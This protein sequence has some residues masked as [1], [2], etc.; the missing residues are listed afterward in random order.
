MEKKPKLKLVGQDGN[1]FVILGLARN[2]ARKAGWTPEKIAE[3]TK[4]AQAG[5]YDNLLRV[6]TEYF[7][8]C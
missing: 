1:A 2:A 7:D 5:D 8:V 6:T 4:A 3:Y